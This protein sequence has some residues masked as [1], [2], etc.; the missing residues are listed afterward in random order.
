[1]DNNI[2]SEYTLK[3]LTNSIPSSRGSVP[4]LIIEIPSNTNLFGLRAKLILLVLITLSISTSLLKLS[5]SLL[6]LSTSLLKL[7]LVTRVAYR[8]AL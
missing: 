3:S 5:I 4:E 6:K 8:K 2:D 7:R 1:M